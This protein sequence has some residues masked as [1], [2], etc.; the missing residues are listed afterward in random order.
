MTCGSKICETRTKMGI[1]QEKLGEIVGVSRQTV[2]K[3]ELDEAFPEPTKLIRLCRYIGVSADELLSYLDAADDTGMDGYGV[4]RGENREIVLTSMFALF[5]YSGSDKI[6]MRLYKGDEK[7]KSLCAVCERD[8]KS[9]TTEFS[10]ITEKSGDIVDSGGRIGYLI[11]TEFDK[12]VLNGMR[13]IE[14]IN[15]DRSGMPLPSVGEYGVARCLSEWRKMSEYHSESSYF[16]FNLCTDRLEYVFSIMPDHEN[17]YCG[18]SNNR[19]FDL[20][21][22]CGAQYFRLRNYDDNDKPFCAFYADLGYEPAY[23]KIPAAEVNTTDACSVRNSSAGRVGGSGLIFFVKR[24]SDDTIILA[25]CGGDEY[26]YNRDGAYC[27]KI[28]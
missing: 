28:I 9:K 4:Y 22:I 23:I 12:S 8:L 19:V 24:Y 10:F 18:A 2:S 11:G 26:V 7:R 14:K 27:E 20:G 15:L 3:W 21:L 13:I 5:L 6:G 16:S 25:G 1:S 17:I